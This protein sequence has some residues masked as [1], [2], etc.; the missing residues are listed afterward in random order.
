MEHFWNDIDARKSKYSEKTKSQCQFAYVEL[1]PAHS[2]EK[3][4]TNRLRHDTPEL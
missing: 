1:N 3:L 4:A 2:G